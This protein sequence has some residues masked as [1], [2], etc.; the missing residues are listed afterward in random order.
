MSVMILTLAL[1]FSNVDGRRDVF[2]EPAA[3]QRNDR[4]I[5]KI[6]EKLKIEFFKPKPKIKSKYIYPMYFDG[7]LDKYKN[8]V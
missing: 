8:V 4:T 1:M 5:E 2:A 6:I 7:P 3:S